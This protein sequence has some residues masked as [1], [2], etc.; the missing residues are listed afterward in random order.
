MGTADQKVQ[1]LQKEVTGIVVSH[2]CWFA[3]YF[4]TV[5]TFLLSVKE[6]ETILTRKKT[7]VLFCGHGPVHIQDVL[8]I[9]II[10]SNWASILASD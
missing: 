4:I 6:L 10:F 9:A 3:G 7:S 2:P 5:S 1:E 8:R